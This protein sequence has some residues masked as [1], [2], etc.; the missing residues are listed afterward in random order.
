MS[1]FHMTCNRIDLSESL[2]MA[3][4]LHDDIAVAIDGGTEAGGNHGRGLVL[5]DDGG[6]VEACAPREL[7]A[8]GDRH[9]DHAAQRRVIDPP[10]PRRGRGRS[11]GGPRPP[12][13]PLTPGPGRPLPKGP[14]H[15]PL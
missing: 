10:P 4:R 9:L 8:P 14:L 13:H 2:D 15:P 12:A 3:L 11:R 1:R 5:D 6:A 7:R